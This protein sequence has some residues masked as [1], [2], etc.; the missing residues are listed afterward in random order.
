MA[1][2][3]SRTS[4]SASSV[5]SSYVSTDST[6]TS[7]IDSPTPIS[8]IQQQH[9][10]I[11]NNFSNSNPDL[12][13]KNNRHQS[14]PTQIDTPL[15]SK[16]TSTIFKQI[17]DDQTD[18][19]RLHHDQLIENNLLIRNNETKNIDTHSNHYCD[20]LPSEYDQQTVSC[21]NF[22]YKTLNGDVIRSVHPPGKGN[23]VNY[24]VSDIFR[25]LFVCTF[26]PVLTRM[27]NGTE[28]LN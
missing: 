19:N 21:E 3:H 17:T 22:T 20:E 23:M 6:K 27:T 8:S 10:D 7:H 24:K 28:D 13:H 5:G 9:F 14:T 18:F 2:T 15:D 16:F 26:F 12:T 11:P 25:G 4:S 1:P